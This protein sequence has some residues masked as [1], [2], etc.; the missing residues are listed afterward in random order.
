MTDASENILTTNQH[1]KTLN[2]WMEQNS[3]KFERNCSILEKHL[4][5]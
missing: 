2:S 4:D 1:K 5:K 3:S